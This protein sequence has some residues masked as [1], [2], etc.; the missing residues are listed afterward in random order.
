VT[1][2]LLVA[3]LVAGCGRGGGDTT[4]TSARRGVPL[5][6]R[7]SVFA[8]ARSQGDTIPN[9]LLPRRIAVRIGLDPA[10]ARRARLYKGSPVYVASSPRLT[11]TFSRRNEVGNCWLNPTVLRGLAAAASICGLGGR[12]DQIVVYGLLP[13]GAERVTVPSPGRR[14]ST[15]PVLGNV[16]IATV[17]SEPPLP[18]RFSFVRDG[19]RFDRPTGIPPEVALRGCGGGRPLP[20]SA[21]EQ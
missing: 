14:A 20:G 12:S 13:D 15:V 5:A 19:R 18:Q 16:F 1:A 4:S 6:E 10:T 8:R 7:F 21:Q 2:G 9:S 17:S 11:C 3:I